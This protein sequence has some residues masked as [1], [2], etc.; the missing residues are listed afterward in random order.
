MAES[1]ESLPIRLVDSFAVCGRGS[2]LQLRG[3]GLIDST[4]K[5][6]VLDHYPIDSQDSELDPD[7]LA[8][9]CFPQNA[10]LSATETSPRR[11]AFALTSATGVRQYVTCCVFWERLSPM[12]I[13]ALE[14]EAMNF[15][16]NQ[17]SDGKDEDQ[18]NGGVALQ[19]LLI[20]PLLISSFC[21]QKSLE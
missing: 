16:Q 14:A 6:C 10:S 1:S 3:R 11:L 19:Q 12:E 13:V 15:Y 21:L 5:P 20:L 4:Y 17:H 9:F 18:L 7:A 8:Q 2:L